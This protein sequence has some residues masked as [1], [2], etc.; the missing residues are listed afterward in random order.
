[1]YY[2]N[3]ELDILELLAQPLQN[4]KIAARLFVSTETVKT[5]LKHP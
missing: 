3:C 4:K 1:V 5:Q 2:C